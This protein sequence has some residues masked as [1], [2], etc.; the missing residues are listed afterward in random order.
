[1][2]LALQIPVNPPA[3][4]TYGDCIL[5]LAADTGY[6]YDLAPMV[7]SANGGYGVAASFNGRRCVALGSVQ[8]LKRRL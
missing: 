3:P 4:P 6:Y 7:R 8:V 1:M 5:R 2:V